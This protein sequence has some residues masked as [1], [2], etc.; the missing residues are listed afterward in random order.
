MS[1]TRVQVVASSVIE[2]TW[3]TPRRPT[4][5]KGTEDDTQRVFQEHFYGNE[6]GKIVYAKTSMGPREI[7]SVANATKGIYQWLQKQ[8]VSWVIDSETNPG[9]E[10]IPR[11]TL[12]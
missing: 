8:G 3:R 12:W 2:R 1:P 9:W 11:D 5:E 7:K 6:H 10:G 4:F